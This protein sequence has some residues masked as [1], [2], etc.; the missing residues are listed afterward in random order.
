MR[1][2]ALSSP[3]FERIGGGHRAGRILASLTLVAASASGACGGALTATAPEPV[4]ATSSKTSTGAGE[5]RLY[6]LPQGY[7]WNFD[8]RLTGLSATLDAVKDP[9][10]CGDGID[11]SWSRLR[12]SLDA[13]DELVR[14]APG[15]LITPDG[16]SR[17]WIQSIEPIDRSIASYAKQDAKKEGTLA[18]GVASIKV[19][20]DAGIHH[21]SNASELLLG[22]QAY[23]V[24]LTGEAIACI[25][26]NAKLN[27]NFHANSN[28]R[29]KGKTSPPVWDRIV[30]GALEQTLVQASAFDVG[31]EL[32]APMLRVKGGLEENQISARVD[33]LGGHSRGNGS[34]APEVKR[35]LTEQR[36]NELLAQTNQYYDRTAIIAVH[37]DAEAEG[38]PMPALAAATGDEAQVPP[39]T[40]VYFANTSD[41]DLDLWSG[42][43]PRGLCVVSRGGPP[44]D[45]DAAVRA[46]VKRDISR[47]FDTG[48]VKTKGDCAPLRGPKPL[49]YFVIN[50]LSGKSY[51]V[52]PNEVSRHYHF[53]AMAGDAAAAE[54]SALAVRAELTSKQRNL[55][56]LDRLR[57]G[58]DSLDAHGI[59]PEVPD[60]SAH[61]LRSEYYDK[62]VGERYPSASNALRVLRSIVRLR[63]S[64]KHAH[65]SLRYAERDILKVLAGGA[66]RE[67]GLKPW[68]PTAG[69]ECKLQWHSDKAGD[70]AR[71]GEWRLFCRG[72]LLELRN[73]EVWSSDFPADIAPP[74]LITVGA[75]ERPGA[76]REGDASNTM[77][78]PA[79]SRANPEVYGY[80]LGDLIFFRREAMPQVLKALSDRM[81]KLDPGKAYAIKTS[82]TSGLEWTVTES[83]VT[84]VAATEDAPLGIAPG[85]SRCARHYVQ[86]R[87]AQ[88]VCDAPQGFMID[89]D[90]LG[91]S[92]GLSCRGSSTVVCRSS[93]SGSTRPSS[94]LSIPLIAIPPPAPPVSEG[95]GA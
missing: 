69:N 28:S 83:A 46:A 7:A 68:W 59:L 2:R 23:E 80:I 18:A 14:S 73:M 93:S 26:L 66:S 16:P 71:D 62:L 87:I 47:W 72:H 1:N 10:V 70:G 27:P 29:G 42:P 43:L 39:E 84:Q 35:L 63:T 74:Q 54:A 19:G 57:S 44:I 92:L 5:V 75:D 13:L 30:Y 34:G 12:A 45:D 32:T 90:R 94:G 21:S 86:G 95:G 89:T 91:S 85:Y 20:A 51:Q 31:G 88:L 24:R 76:A 77:S 64:G 81:S 22:R 48:E 53:K 25:R 65:A 52:D 50:A 11:E 79:P 49:R 58:G 60:D 37:E 67:Y 41:N 55:W 38:D 6:E 4:G 17:V 33:Q 40:I 82:A 56:L 61:W 8:R 3:P 15:G 9:S 36:L 78:M